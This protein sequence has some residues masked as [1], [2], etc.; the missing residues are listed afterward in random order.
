[1]KDLNLKR[2]H[3]RALRSEENGKDIRSSEVKKK[4]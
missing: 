1:M 4:D 3:F 2:K